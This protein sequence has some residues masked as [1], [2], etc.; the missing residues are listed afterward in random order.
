LKKLFAVIF[1]SKHATR[2][3]GF[4]A[5]NAEKIPLRHRAGL[6]AQIERRG[7]GTASDE[8]RLRDRLVSSV[9]RA[10][11]AQSLMR[12][13]YAEWRRASPS[14]EPMRIDTEGMDVRACVL[15][16]NGNERGQRILNEILSTGNQ[17]P[18]VLGPLTYEKPLPRGT[19]VSF[20][21]EGYPLCCTASK[22]LGPY[23]TGIQLYRRDAKKEEE[24]KK[25]SKRE[26]QMEFLRTHLQPGDIL[27]VSQ[28]GEFETVLHEYFET[29]QRALMNTTF[30]ATHI[31]LVNEERQL[32]HINW[33]GKHV[34][35]VDNLIYKYNGITVARL[36]GGKE[37]QIAFAQNA[38]ARYKQVKR[39]NMQG[40]F[41]RGRALEQ[42]EKAPKTSTST[43][44][45]CVDLLKDGAEA[46]NI[47]DLT[48]CET[49]AEIAA[50][51]E[52]EV[53]YS[54]DFEKE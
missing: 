38:F 17:A 49:P 8:K 23:R 46:S 48:S 26:R 24:R 53:A 37:R 44:C 47:P 18:D 2:G 14:G 10:E 50:C 42:G 7:E 16:R 34:G 20:D 31:M 25:M 43:S 12:Q 15:R 30:H 11:L 4:L 9:V 3:I 21:E 27:L 13:G 22:D 40:L 39:F 1:G 28:G 32:F 33:K 29:K 45:T 35:S 54:L 5:R 51:R 52:I 19:Y 41:A 6:I 36:R